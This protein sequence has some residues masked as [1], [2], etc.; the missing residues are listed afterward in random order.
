MT[1]MSALVLP[2]ML[3][4]DA[5]VIVNISSVMQSGYISHSVYSASKAYVSTLSDCMQKTYRRTG[6]DSGL[7]ILFIHF[8]CKFKETTKDIRKPK[9]RQ[10][11]NNL[12]YQIDATV[13]CVL[14][15]HVHVLCTCTMCTCIVYMRSSHLQCRVGV[16]WSCALQY[17]MHPFLSPHQGVHQ[18]LPQF[19]N[20]G[21]QMRYTHPATRPPHSRVCMVPR[22]ACTLA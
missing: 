12:S 16:P 8:R 20:N 17:G 15:V 2:Q 1:S 7:S 19:H 13:Y 21:K 18:N 9:C 10:T 11:D 14:C 3:E 5:G 6:I 4:K 22:L